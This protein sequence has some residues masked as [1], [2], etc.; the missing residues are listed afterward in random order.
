MTNFKRTVLLLLLQ[1][2]SLW[3]WAAGGDDIEY[4]VKAAYLYKF[5]AYIEWPPATF[6]NANSPIVVGILGADD[7]VAALAGSAAPLINNRALEVR[8]LKP[9]EPLSGVHIL[10]I[11]RQENGRLKRL[12]ESVQAEAV[13]TVTEF[14]GALGI[15]SIINFVP[16]DDRI[17]FEVSLPQAEH[18]RLKISARLLSVAQK[19]ESRRP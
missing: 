4:R 8:A 19:I 1:G 10:F 12:L 7:A 13:L 17:R 3:S 14:P 15:G 16:V 6:T 11:G 18:N 9:G 2:F 5:A